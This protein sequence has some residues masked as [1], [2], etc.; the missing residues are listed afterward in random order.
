VA[1]S[2]ASV[3]LAGGTPVDHAL[4]ASPVSRPA[5]RRSR[6]FVQ[7]RYPPGTPSPFYDYDWRVPGSGV[8]FTSVAS[9]LAESEDGRS[10]AELRR[11]RPSVS[12]HATCGPASTSTASRPSRRDP[13]GHDDCHDRFGHLVTLLVVIL[14]SFCCHF[15][16]CR[17][18]RIPGH[19]LHGQTLQRGV[20][21]GETS[22]LSVDFP[23]ARDYSSSDERGR[24]EYMVEPIIEELKSLILLLE[25]RLTSE[26]LHDDAAI[27]EDLGLD[28][29]L[30][31]TLINMIEDRFAFTF[32]ED[33]LNMDTFANIRFL[34]EF[35]STRRSSEEDSQSSSP[36]GVQAGKN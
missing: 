24:T 11:P 17:S 5:V 2:E 36:P 25:P 18:A 35:I 28:S 8:S 21:I 10:T 7:P 12:V 27:V 22:S 3:R 32:A 9:R 15:S 33:D 19:L 23:Y 6:T 34:A 1:L 31:V 13:L 29:I 30:V 26:Q 20:C 14:L 4:A 16:R